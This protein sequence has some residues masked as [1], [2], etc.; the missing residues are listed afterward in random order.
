MPVANANRQV[1]N[2]RVRSEIEEQAVLLEA[3]VISATYDE[4]EVEALR[5][6]V[7]AALRAVFGPT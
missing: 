3:L 6:A 5:D 4:A 2:P 1:I 7:V